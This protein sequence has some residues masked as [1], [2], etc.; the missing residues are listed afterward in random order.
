MDCERAEAHL[1]MRAED[2]VRWA[3][4]P[5]R[6]GARVSRVAQALTAAG[7]LDEET[8]RRILD[9]FELACALR[10][11]DPVVRHHLANAGASSP[12]PYRAPRPRAADPGSGGRRRLR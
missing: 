11:P 5:G 1:R 8:A 6:G 9:D 2:E 12:L 10:H 7:A 3:V 4:L